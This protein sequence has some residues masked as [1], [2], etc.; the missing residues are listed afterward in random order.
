MSDCRFCAR[1]YLSDNR[2]W[3]TE[4]LN[5]IEVLCGVVRE[6]P[7]PH[8]DSFMGVTDRPCGTGWRCKR[9]REL[10]GPPRVWPPRTPKMI[11]EGMFWTDVEPDPQRTLEG[12]L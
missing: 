10:T 2:V 6:G 1:A 4:C 3:E 9:F 11:H 8:V 7:W 12:W 5:R